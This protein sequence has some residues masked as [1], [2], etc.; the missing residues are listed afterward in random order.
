MRY[1]RKRLNACSGTFRSKQ[2]NTPGKMGANKNIKKTNGGEINEREIA[3]A[4]RTHSSYRASV[5]VVASQGRV[6][7]LDCVPSRIDGSSGSGSGDGGAS[8]LT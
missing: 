4:N 3:S 2:L 7:E 6:L 1:G 8:R 5:S